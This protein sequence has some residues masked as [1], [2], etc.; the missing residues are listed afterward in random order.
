MKFLLPVLLLLSGPL[1]VQAYN[2]ILVE[3]PEP[4]AVIPIEDDPYI[5]HHYL[6][7]LDGNPQMYELTTDVAITLR[8]SLW[9][10]AYGKS[11]PFA[12]IMVRQNDD[13]GGVTEIARLNQPLSEW[14]KIGSSVLGLTL[15]KSQTIEQA[16]APGT[17]RFE[18]STP[19][20]RGNYVL[21]LGEESVSR[22]F[23]G[24][25]SDVGTIQKHFGYTPLHLL[26]SSYI[27]IPL[28]ILGV[29]YG[30]YSFRRYRR[31][32]SHV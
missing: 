22:G 30:I 17:Y 23:F 3:Q 29:L 25:F 14:N 18:V 9:Q 8:L 11:V 13:D 16:L 28:G 15:L 10:R 2:P 20:N 5:E 1:L 32:R 4:Y 27:F 24:G 31:E 26:F 12:L 6:G 21:H 7:S 19:D